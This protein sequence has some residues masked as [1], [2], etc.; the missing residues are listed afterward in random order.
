MPG[1]QVVGA[2]EI[3]GAHMSAPAWARPGLH[4]G[5]VEIYWAATATL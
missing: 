1:T 2:I 4:Y 5:K 3:D